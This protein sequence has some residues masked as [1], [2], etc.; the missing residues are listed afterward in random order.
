MRIAFALALVSGAIFLGGAG[1]GAQ[2]AKTAAAPASNPKR[3]LNPQP[4]RL[5]QVAFTGDQKARDAL[6]SGQAN[7]RAL[8]SADL[9]GN[10]TPDLVAGYADGNG[11][12]IVTVQRGNPD[13]FAPRDDSVFLRMQPGYNPDS[14]VSTV[15]TYLVPAPADFV[16]VG[17]FDRDNR[18]DVLV[19][20]ARRRFVSARRR[21]SGW[22]AGAREEDRFAGRLSPA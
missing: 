2:K 3:Y 12:G 19:A 10:G 14:L 18:K 5:M 4:A 1:L 13:A 15:E 22:F 11:G 20:G 21:W 9:D 17:D 16:Q 8:A 6:L 7:A